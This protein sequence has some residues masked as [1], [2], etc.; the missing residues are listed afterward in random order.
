MVPG[1][2]PTCDLR[3]RGPIA[4]VNA[5]RQ[6][7][8]S[9]LAS[10]FP[11]YTPR[12]QVLPITWRWALRGRDCVDGPESQAETS[13]LDDRLRRLSLPSVPRLRSFANDTL[14]D[15]LLYG[16]L[17]SRHAIQAAVA[18]ELCALRKRFLKR[19]PGFTGGVSVAGHSLGSLILFDLLA[20]QGDGQTPWV[21]QDPHSVSQLDF[22]PCH[23][24][25]LGSPIAAYLA[26]RGQDTLCGYQLSGCAQVFNIFHPLDP[27]AYRLEPLLV[28]DVP[29]PV[30]LPHHRGRERLHREVRAAILRLSVPLRAA[31]KALQHQLAGGG[32][33][34]E[35]VTQKKEGGA[36][37]GQH[38]DVGE[39]QRESVKKSDKESE[40]TATGMHAKES[41]AKGESDQEP[42]LA[43]KTNSDSSDV[44]K[45]D[46]AEAAPM[47]RLNG[48]RRVDFVLQEAPI[49]SVNEY[50]F[51]LQSH[52]CYWY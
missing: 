37:E 3:C 22:T 51:A 8:L 45:P 47:G 21:V 20:G 12:L 17:P 24:F 10:H 46:G 50:L 36:M 39:H 1:I 13:G 33:T 30:L 32:E 18:Q 38:Q 40:E 16:S 43:P 7:S 34:A 52:L 19:N 42:G 48:G 5:F 26:A 15:V 44:E 27:V 14:L 11:P 23:L 2:G 28:N 41:A 25:A 9:L 4:C 35:E 49:E 31:W 29:P 6:T